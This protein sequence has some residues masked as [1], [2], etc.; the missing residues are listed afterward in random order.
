MLL[1]FQPFSFVHFAVVAL[2]VVVWTF[3]IRFARRQRPAASWTARDRSPALRRLESSLGVV[4][5]L[6]WI[7]G[8][9]AW[10]LRLEIDWAYELPLHVCDITSILVP[11]A[12]WFR[13]RGFVTLIYFWGITLSVQAIIT[14]VLSIG[15][16][17]IGFWVFWLHHTT[18]VA[19]AFYMVI[20]HGFRPTWRDYGVAVLA[21][22]I[23]VVVILPIDVV[24]GFNYGFLGDARPNQATLLD[25]L[26]P[27]PWRVGVM[28]GLSYAVWALM[29]L[30]WEWGRRFGRHRRET[31]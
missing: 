13:K 7:V 17:T 11:F 26:G 5:L 20:V 14:P 21:G 28:T 9:G 6:L 27:W 19:T 2:F 12:Y 16:A 30:P 18:A 24:F 22:A 31:S 4:A 1:Y 29:V 8:N 10:I 3:I 15:P 25:V 23:Y